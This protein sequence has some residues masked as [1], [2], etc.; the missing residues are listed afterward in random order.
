MPAPLL[1]T[2]SPLCTITLQA[3]LKPSLPVM[4][5]PV[6]IPV[7]APVIPA[8]ISSF[9][10]ADMA[11]ICFVTNGFIAQFCLFPAKPGRFTRCQFTAFN[12]LVYALSFVT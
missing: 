9:P 4:F 3:S 8:E 12:T 1:Y 2:A 10:R 11:V 7:Q 6:N 5:L